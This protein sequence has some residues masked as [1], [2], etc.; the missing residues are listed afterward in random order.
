MNSTRKEKT[1]Q[2]RRYSPA[3]NPTKDSLK[4]EEGEVYTFI[5]VVQKNA[6]TKRIKT[7]QRM[8]LLKCYRHHAVFEDKKGMRHSYRYWDIEKLL[9]GEQR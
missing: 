6:S 5:F 1:M 9:L 7:K 3:Q 8:R 2:E 4:L